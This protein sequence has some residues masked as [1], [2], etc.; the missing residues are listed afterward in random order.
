MA[1]TMA[2]KLSSPLSRV[3]TRL[4]PTIGGP[5]R[6]LMTRMNWESPAAYVCAMVGGTGGAG[7]D[8]LD[9]SRIRTAVS[10]AAPPPQMTRVRT[11]P[12]SACRDLG[13]IGIG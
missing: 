9:Q 2:G 7:D 12:V 3:R 10:A 13:G 4:P 8:R 6:L 5:R 1:A 11:G